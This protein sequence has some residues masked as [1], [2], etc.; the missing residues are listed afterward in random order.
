MALAILESQSPPISHY[1][2][3][4]DDRLF[5]LTICFSDVLERT[6]GYYRDLENRASI[7]P[8]V[9]MVVDSIDMNWLEQ[10]I[11]VLTLPSPT[12]LADAGLVHHVPPE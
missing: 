10:R 3:R 12:P 1:H 5:D 6:K 9:R 8:R 11:D 2:I 7:G 4:I